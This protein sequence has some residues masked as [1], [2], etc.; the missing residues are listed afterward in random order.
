M[1]NGYHVHEANPFYVQAVAEHRELHAAVER[2]HKLLTDRPDGDATPEHVAEATRDI[3]EL[4]DKLAQHFAQEEEGG[5]LEEAVGRFPQVA[6]QAETLQRQ[7][8]TLLKLANLM[9][10]DA[11]TGDKAPAVWRKLQADY[12]P[13]AKRLHAHEAAENVLLQRAFNEDLGIET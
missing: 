8:G 5:Y 2:I 9:L 7:H 3:R 1:T 4:R 13:F 12:D 10:A 6:L 11:E